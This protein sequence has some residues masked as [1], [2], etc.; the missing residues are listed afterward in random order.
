[1]AGTTIDEL[2]MTLYEM[3]QDARSV[4]LG[5]RCI[6]ERDKALDILDEIRAD[7]PAELKMAREIVEK[8]NEVISAGKREYDTIKKQAEDYAKQRVNEHE[9]VTEA[10]KRAAEII[11]GAE[12]RSRE[13]M[14]AAGAYCEDAMR[15][16]EDAAGPDRRRDQTVAHPVPPAAARQ[17]GF[18]Q[19]K[20]GFEA[21][22]TD[23]QA[24]EPPGRRPAALSVK[25]RTYVLCF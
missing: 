17:A 2:I 5:D 4:P 9:V 3:I 23:S 7:L 21:A 16:A 24:D 18:R 22:K 1:M 14:K 13:I 10:R 15:R 6:I 8:R 25:M 12:N 11:A 20:R 19:L